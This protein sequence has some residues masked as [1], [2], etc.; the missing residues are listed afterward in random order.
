MRLLEIIDKKPGAGVAQKMLKNA[1]R[2]QKSA[3]L[4]RADLPIIRSTAGM[5][6]IHHQR[7]WSV[8]ANACI[9]GQSG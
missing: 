6:R 3:E 8:R 2:A 5:V 1:S 9:M 7:R 4:R